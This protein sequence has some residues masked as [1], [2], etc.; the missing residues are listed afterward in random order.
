MVAPLSAASRSN[1]AVR[2][3]PV[4]LAGAPP[5]LVMDPAMPSQMLSMATFSSWKTIFLA[6]GGVEVSNSKQPI[7]PSRV[8]AHLFESRQVV[9]V[10]AVGSTSVEARSFNTS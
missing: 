4:V 7:L 5:H 6:E 9:S 1:L 3:C 8:T 10:T 2:D